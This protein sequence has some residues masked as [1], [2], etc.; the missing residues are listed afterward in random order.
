MMKKKVIFAVSL[1]VLL[2][3]SC[4]KEEETVTYKTLSG[5][6]AVGRMPEYVNPGDKF[7][8]KS[9]GVSIPESETD[10]SLEI[11]Y[12]YKAS[13]VE[14][15]DTTDTYEVVIPEEVGDFSIVAT[16]SADG[17]YSKS[18]T[19]KTT[20]VSDKSLSG[21]DKANLSQILDSRDSK[22]Y[23][24]VN[25]GGTQ[26]TADNIAYYEKDE[27]GNYTFGASYVRVKATEDVMGGFYSWEEARTACPAGWRIP[28]VAE[29]DAL[30]SA[31]GDLMCDAYFN[32]SRL[33]EFYPDM[34]ITNKTGLCALPFGYATIAAGEYEFAGIN[35]YA[36][37]WADDNGK[38]LCKYIYVATPSVLVWDDPSDTDFAAQLRC[39]RE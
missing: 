34:H 38:P 2:C 28:T 10:K 1:G 17:Y 33:W 37:Y 12:T 29:W 16:A 35:D 31:A 20:V 5:T 21:F 36:L 39:V 25:I 13:N 15:K 9:E 18:L 4:K 14:K 7:S 30:G 6:L 19:L 8:F 23:H 22:R 11:V 27:E 3:F 26:W 32:N 24:V